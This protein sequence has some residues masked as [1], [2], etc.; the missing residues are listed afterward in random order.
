MYCCN[1]R[2][3]ATLVNDFSLRWKKLL[4][5]PVFPWQRLY[6]I[7]VHVWGNDIL[8]HKRKKY[9]HVRLKLRS[10]FKVPD[11]RRRQNMWS[12]SFALQFLLFRA[13]CRLDHLNA[14]F[15]ALSRTLN[16]FVICYKYLYTPIIPVRNKTKLILI[17]K[18]FP[19]HIT[20]YSYNIG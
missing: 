5:S 6:H 18:K 9:T 8:R 19:R 14:K 13:V 15:C 20:Y 17:A 2:H 1:S 12:L 4:R 11:S 7:Y 16:A 3:N 10:A